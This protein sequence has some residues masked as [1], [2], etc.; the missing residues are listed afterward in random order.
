MKIIA[1]NPSGL[2]NDEIFDFCPNK[3]LRLCFSAFS[4]TTI[5]ISTLSLLIASSG[6][7][8][9]AFVIIR[10]IGLNLAKALRL[11]TF[12]S[13]QIRTIKRCQVLLK[14]EHQ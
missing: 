11:K 7:E 9:A 10:A 13:L 3:I 1:N 14:R 5:Y 12:K 8:D 6:G 4:Q 2:V